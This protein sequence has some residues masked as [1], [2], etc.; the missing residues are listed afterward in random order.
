MRSQVEG[1]P[2]LCAMFLP[3]CFI[4]GDDVLHGHAAG[5][6]GDTADFTGQQGGIETE[7]R[8]DLG[9]DVTGALVPVV[10]RD[11]RDPAHTG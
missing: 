10:G 1:H 11:E 8:P 9:P 4:Q 6:M 2:A 7:L 5:Q 3:P